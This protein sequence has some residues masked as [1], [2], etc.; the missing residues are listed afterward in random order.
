MLLAGYFFSVLTSDFFQFHNHFTDCRTP[1]KSD[2]LVARPLPK[3]RATQTQNKHIHIRKIHAL[4]GIRTHNPGFRA[5][6]DS[7]CPIPLVYRDR[8]LAGS[9][10]L[11]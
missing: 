8:L 7:T 3:Q 6:E 4:R 10:V 1:W 5:S 9:T 11:N 2:Q